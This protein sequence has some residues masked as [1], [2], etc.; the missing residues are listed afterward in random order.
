MLI[1]VAVLVLAIGSLTGCQREEAAASDDKP[2]TVW[3]FAIEE[4]AGGVQHRYAMRFKELIEQRSEGRIKVVVYPYGTL[5]TS[6]EVTELLR[7]GTVKFAMASPGHLG[8]LIPEVQVLLLH[9][10]FSDDQRVNQRAL[11]DP[12]LKNSFDRLYEEKGLKLL[13]MF[14]EGWQVWTTQNPIRRPERFEGVKIRVMTS[15]VL[16]AAYRAYGANPVPLP[17]GEV[18]SALQ[19][20][21]IDAQVNPVFAIEQMKFYEVVNWMIFARHAPF[22]SSAVTN[23]DFFESLSPERQRMVQR[24]I[25]E[26]RDYIFDVQREYNRD[27][28]ETIKEDEPELNII[29]DLTDEQ[30]DRFREASLPVR[31]QY[32][33]MV[34]PRGREVLDQLLEAVRRAEARPQQSVDEGTEAPSDSEDGSAAEAETAGSGNDR[35]D[36]GEEAP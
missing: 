24:T 25:G 33:E 17:Y 27:L 11:E 22:I 14:Q 29:D 6:D 23:R 1:S 2:A 20:D 19:L 10:V 21:M 15:P 35:S 16:L 8:T 12:T 3:R 32:V 31:E 28:L 4:T 5:G 18:Y 13:S 7:M 34:G 36:N 9:F 30:R 26:L